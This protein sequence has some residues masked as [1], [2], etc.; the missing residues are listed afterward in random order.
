MGLLH[1]FFYSVY[2]FL[3]FTGFIEVISGGFLFFSPR[4]VFFAC[5]DTL[6]C[7]ESRLFCWGSLGS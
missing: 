6:H 3:P 2:F 4:L 1:H 7:R 5:S